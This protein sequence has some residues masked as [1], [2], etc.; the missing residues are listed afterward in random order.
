M[1]YTSKVTEIGEI[2]LGFLREKMLI[3][4]NENAPAELAE[5]AVLHSIE[6]MYRDIEAGDTVQLGE[7][8]YEVTAVGLEANH[9]LKSMGHCTFKF[10]GNDK[11]E[12][13]GEV[14]LKGDALPNLKVGD[15]FNIIYKN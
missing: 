14:E 1:N 8:S 4:F 6:D 12:L 15:S 7:N 2:A 10:T 5:I 3:M 9:T 11:T 13:P